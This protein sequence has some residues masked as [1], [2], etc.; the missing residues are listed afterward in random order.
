MADIDR[1]RSSATP[2]FVAMS[3][4]DAAKMD[5]TGLFVVNHFGVNRHRVTPF[6][7]KASRE[8]EENGFVVVS[9]C[10]SP[11]SKRR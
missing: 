11:F 5:L 8:G 1:L 9:N 10:W 6:E 7:V 3:V 2:Q 4:I